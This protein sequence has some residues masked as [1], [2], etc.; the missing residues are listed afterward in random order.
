MSLLET[1]PH[2]DSFALGKNYIFQDKG[3]CAIRKKKTG[4]LIGSFSY[5][6]IRRR[7]E[8]AN[9]KQNKYMYPSSTP[10]IK[11]GPTFAKA[12][13]VGLKYA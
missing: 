4:G 13:A 1:V 8:K 6:N 10:L 9:C 2:F 11:R 3:H 7:N 12:L 5:T